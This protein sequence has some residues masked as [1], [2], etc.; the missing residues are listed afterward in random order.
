[1]FKHKQ[2][3][4]NW[5]KIKTRVLQKWDKLDNADVEQTKGDAQSLSRLV[6]DKYGMG[7]HFHSEYK[8]ICASCIHS[9]KEESKTQTERLP[10]R[11][12]NMTDGWKTNQGMQTASN[13]SAHENAD[14]QTDNVSANQERN[15]GWEYQADEV[16]SQTDN[17]NPGQ[18]VNVKETD[19]FK[20]S[21]QN[22]ISDRSYSAPDEFISIQ[23]PGRT[24]V[25]IPLGGSF[26]SAS[27]S[28]ANNAAFNSFEDH[29]RNTKKL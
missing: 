13:V 5:E 2:I 8:A 9:G 11:S 26:S 28:S 22:I 1:M 20:Q 12:P 23:S 15:S 10:Y 29:S 6:Y 27:N 14:G 7:E 16:S 3:E 25:D 17:I 21:T 19:E 24:R 18:Q 4:N